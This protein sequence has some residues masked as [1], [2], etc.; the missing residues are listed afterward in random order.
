MDIEGWVV[1]WKARTRLVSYNEM[2]VSLLPIIMGLDLPPLS[3]FSPF[4]C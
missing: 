4:V 3:L 1:E 2:D